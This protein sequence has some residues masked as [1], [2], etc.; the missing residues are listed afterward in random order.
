MCRNEQG[1]VI[2]DFS[3]CGY[4]GGGVAL[5]EAPVVMTVGPEDDGDDTERLQAAIDA[6]SG[7]VPDADGFRGALLLRRGAY[8]I[9]GTLKVRTSGVVLRGE[10]DEED[11]TILVA[12]GTGKRTLITFSGTGGPQEAEGTRQTIVDS[13]VPVGAR[14][15]E[16]ADASGFAVGD[17]VIVHRPS[18]AEW[19]AAL[20]MDRIEMKHP[21]VRQWEPGSY[22]FRF[23]RV[24]TGRGR[25]P[26]E[27]GCS[28]GQCV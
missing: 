28:D 12:A 5:P 2:L 3:H 26:G 27:S 9:G 23:D 15:F 8:R 16:V 14:T 11:G 1:N 7:R 25:Q 13:Y 22:D 10:G 6:V 4:M 18:T 21:N 20:G 17:R 19:I 24:I